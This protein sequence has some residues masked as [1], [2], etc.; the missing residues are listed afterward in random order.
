MFSGVAVL[1]I[2]YALWNVAL[3][4]GGVAKVGQIQLLQPFVTILIAV[5]LLGEFV[6]ATMVAFAVA[7]AIVVGL[8][9][10]AVVKRSGPTG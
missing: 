2:G 3:A 10:R 5:P 1:F 6:D 8:G 4:W 9:Q 7:V